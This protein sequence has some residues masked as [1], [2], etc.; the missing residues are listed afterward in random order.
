MGDTM[1]LVMGKYGEYGD[2]QVWP[3]S[4]H[5]TLAAAERAAKREGKLFVEFLRAD[6]LE[7]VYGAR[8]VEGLA[9]KVGCVPPAWPDG[10]TPDMVHHYSLCKPTFRIEAVKVG[11]DEDG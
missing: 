1:W 4:V 9:F 6:D 8:D 7:E 5:A 11:G 2:V 3:V 10:R